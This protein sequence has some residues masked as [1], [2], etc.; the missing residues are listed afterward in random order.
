MK[1]KSVLIIALSLVLMGGLFLIATHLYQ[2]EQVKN[3]GFQK[4]ED[5]KLL[6]PDHAVRK[7]SVSAK[8][9]V[10][11]FFDPQCESCREFYPEMD[12]IMQEYQGKIQLVLRYAAFH[13]DS[14]FAIKILEAARIQNRYWEVLEVLYEHQPE[15]GSHHNP[16]PDL[17]WKYLAQVDVDLKKLKADM[18]NPDTQ[19][20]IE[21]DTKDGQHLG[22]RLTP[23]FYINGKA[24]QDFGP[25]FL[26][27]AINEALQEEVSP[28]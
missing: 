7:G 12:A 22:V 25:D 5:F 14:I 3:P 24:L 27:Q 2:E 10:V 21:Q 16:Q 11:E 23:S 18:N 8:V 15:W 26:R 20:I 13:G 19:R 1:N 9:I 17:V 28:E 4:R 6:V